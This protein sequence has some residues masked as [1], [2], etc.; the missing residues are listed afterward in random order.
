MKYKILN[1][2]DIKVSSIAIGS[3]NFGSDLDEKQSY[4]IL[5]YF[6]ENG[7]TVIDT[8][9]GYSNWLEG[10]KSRSEKLIGRWLR[11]KKRN[12]VIISTKGGLPYHKTP[13][14]SRLTHDEVRE[15]IVGSL[16]R[17]NV[18]YIDIYWLHRDDIKKGVAEI[19]EMLHMFVKEG[20]TRYI[21]MSNWTH[22]RIQEANNYARNNGLTE[23]IASQIQY[24]M[25]IPNIENN[26]PTLVLM[27]DKEYKYFKENKMNVFAFSSQAKGFFS[28]IEKGGVE[29]LS[30]KARDRFFNAQSI[31]VYEKLKEVSKITGYSVGQLVISTLSSNKDF[32]VIPIVS[33]K[34]TEQLRETMSGVDVDLPRDIINFLTT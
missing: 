22:E 4:E 32:N 31:S 33:C 20:K 15:D 17:L 13:N 26:D 27:N 10:E 11:G 5:D 12:S 1:K 2:T 7:G 30:K 28:K 34:N 8:A 29:A 14:V 16:K 3:H 23:I 19:M 24:N 21:G 9:A 25:A 6:T 18:D